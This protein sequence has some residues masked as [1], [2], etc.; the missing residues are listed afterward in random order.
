MDT[1]SSALVRI[2]HLVATHTDVQDRIRAEI[3]AAKQ[4]HGKALTYD[5]LEALWRRMGVSDA[6]MDAFVDAHRGATEEVVRAYEDELE[7]ML[8]VKRERMA[9]FVQNARRE[10]GALWDEM[11]STRAGLGAPPVVLPRAG[12]PRS[13]DEP[14][15][16]EDEV[17]ALHRTLDEVES[18]VR[19][20]R[21]QLDSV[22]LNSLD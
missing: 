1:T 16:V 13:P 22:D 12:K 7:G 15:S 5:Q 9:E 14:V 10:V 6:Q 2:L 8:E 18:R 21:G 3:R 17:S 19:A 11:A 4:E 20:I